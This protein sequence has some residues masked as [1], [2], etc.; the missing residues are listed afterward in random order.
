MSWLSRNPFSTLWRSPWNQP[1]SRFRTVLTGLGTSVAV[2]GLAALG[3]WTPLE[4]LAYRLL[5]NLRGER[6]WDDRVVVIAID[7]KTLRAVDEY[8]L[9]RDYHIELLEQLQSVDSMV[10]GFDVLMNE[11]SDS[12]EEALSS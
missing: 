8:P 2:M 5:F 9:S 1:Q 6:P 12:D 4:Q 3:T 10:I 11:A 7:E